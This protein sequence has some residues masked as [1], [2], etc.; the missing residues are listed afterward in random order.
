MFTKLKMCFII[1][2]ADLVF[3]QADCLNKHIK[4]D[5][6]KQMSKTYKFQK[7]VFET[8][9]KYYKVQND[10]SFKTHK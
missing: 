8:I 1:A 2:K 9:W 7:L 4:S 5:L 3:S 6:K 10:F